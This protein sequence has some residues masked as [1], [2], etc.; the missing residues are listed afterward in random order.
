MSIEIDLF[1]SALKKKRLILKGEIACLNE[2]IKAA[3]SDKKEARL[4]KRLMKS[5]D[6][7]SIIEQELCEI[8]KGCL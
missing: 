8:N 6:K 7:L 4:K 5:K 1:C 3:N 2:Q